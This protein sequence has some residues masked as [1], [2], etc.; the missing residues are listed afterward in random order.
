[1]EKKDCTVQGVLWHQKQ[2]YNIINK[3]K[4]IEKMF[5]FVALFCV[6]STKW[7]L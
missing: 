1:L 7:R 4:L 2:K 3:E 5:F 6:L